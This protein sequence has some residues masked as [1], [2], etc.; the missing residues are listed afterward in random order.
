MSTR[1]DELIAAARYSMHEHQRVLSP[2][3]ARSRAREEPPTRGFKKAL[4]AAAARG[5]ALIGEI[6]RASP[7]RGPIAPDLRPQRLARAYERG[8]AAC[9]SVL[10][11]REFF[12]GSLEDLQVAREACELPA[13]RKDF[14]VDAYQLDEA[15]LFGADAVLLIAAALDAQQLREL[16]AAARELRLDVL[17]EVH[18]EAELELAAAAKPDLLGI[19]NRDLK[20]LQVDR[21]TFARLA[22]A[23][24]GIAPLVAESGVRDAKDA[25]AAIDAGAS[26]LLVGE[27]L[28]AA[29]DP[30]AKVRELVTA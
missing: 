28:S 10:T 29:A 4:N 24:R 26:A 22:P 1:L 23:A 20:T 7:S 5:I 21:G 15:R 9:L 3:D 8:G 17:V 19:N 11:E 16:S 12:L 27:A 30:E 6:K 13:L 2:A 18:D 14:I 25:R